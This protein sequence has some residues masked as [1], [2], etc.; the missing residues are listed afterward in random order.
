[1]DS[2]VKMMYF[3]PSCGSVLGSQKPCFC[4][5]C[6]AEMVASPYKATRW[7]DMTTEERDAAAKQWIGL[8]PAERTAFIESGALEAQQKKPVT[9]TAPPPPSTSS[10][11]SLLRGTA[12]IIMI[13]GILASLI[14]GFSMLKRTPLMGIAVLIIGIL[15]S[16]ISVAGLMVFLDMASDISKIRQLLERDEK[17]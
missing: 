9:Q 3:C 5:K 4:V 11:V 2:N 10:W 8:S 17:R 13:A 6:G 12:Y 16:V 15:V 7:I 1:M 14:V